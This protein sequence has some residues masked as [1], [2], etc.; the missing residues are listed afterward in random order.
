MSYSIVLASTS[1]RRRQLLHEAGI[2]HDALSPGVDDGELETNTAVNAEWWVAALAYLKAQ[3]GLRL[4]KEHQHSQRIVI[5]ADTVVS[6][7]GVVMGQPK[8]Q[9]EAHS[10]IH[11][12]RNGSHFV[13]TGLAFATQSWREVIVDKSRVTV[14]NIPEHA[15][16]RYIDTGDWTGKAG[17]YNL[18]D[19]VNDGWPINVD[20]DPNSVMGLPVARVMRVL[21]SHGWA[22]PHVHEDAS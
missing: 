17:G 6:K 12:L 22:A 21:K 19:R 2:E 20:G 16:N 1:A 14:G 8:D 3:A 10:M 9:H 13:I 11:T 15:I 4:D 7:S 18:R 5:G